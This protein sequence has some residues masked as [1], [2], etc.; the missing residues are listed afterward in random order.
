MES[1]VFLEILKMGEER[2]LEKGRQHLRENLRLLLS[3]RF[4]GLED[5]IAIA[6]MDADQAVALFRVALTA[7]TEHEVLAAL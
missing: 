7:T 5:R 6:G 2:G 3:V 1:P 4:P